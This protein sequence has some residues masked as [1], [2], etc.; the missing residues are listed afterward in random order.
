MA[1]LVKLK[2]LLLGEA[3][4]T[5]SKENSA[6]LLNICMEKHLPY[7]KTVF[8]D[9]KIHLYTSLSISKK[10]TDEL[11]KAGIEYTSKEWGFPLILIR[12]KRRW[13]LMAGAV[14]IIFLLIV[15]QNH[16]WDIR[17]SGNTT[18]T[19]AEVKAELEAAG[20]GIG[21]LIGERDVDQISNSL[22]LSSEKIA[23]M[24][25]NFRGNVAYVTIREK[26]TVSG[27]AGEDIGAPAN[28]VAKRDGVIEYLEVM[29]G[30]AVVGE[31]ESVREGELLISG[32]AENKQG[33]YRTERAIGMVY[34][35]T[36]HFFSV[37]IPLEYD[38][39]E[40]SAPVC[41]KKTLKFFSK[42]I[43]I[44]R[45]SGNLGASCVTIEEENSFSLPGLPSLPVSVVSLLS[46]EYTT[47]SARRTE[48]E[49]SELAFFEL[50]KFITS[51]LSEASL[52]RKTIRT[53]MT[54]NAFILE[55]DIICSENIARTVPIG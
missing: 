18:L 16:V 15:S 31:R 43:N 7:L 17:I 25:I 29:R 24:S 37:R 10:L 12:Y 21:S 42:Q 28:I 1:L 19:A 36:N 40:L 14:I 54:D 53:E 23:W 3:R 13:G 47:V 33:E 51:E 11:K 30:T 45:K 9:E 32:V 44:F 49:A 22:L 55:C 5:V 46:L 27:E 41:V 26:E 52:L 6:L 34:A 2:N 20:F 8:S 50:Q 39:K 4:V 35:V 48:S 38:K